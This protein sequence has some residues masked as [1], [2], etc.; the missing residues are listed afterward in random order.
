MPAV[1]QV[2]TAFAEFARWLADNRTLAVATIAI[3][4]N[5]FEGWLKFE[6]LMWLRE[7]QHLAIEGLTGDAGLEYK[8]SLDPASDDT[9]DVWKQCDLWVRATRGGFHYVELK[10]PFANKNSGKMLASAGYDFWY[11]S[12]LR[13]TEEEAASGSAIVVGVGF[14]DDRWEA[15]RARVRRAA[16][17]SSRVKPVRT[18]T[19]GDGI[20]FDVWTKTY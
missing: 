18:G 17:I 4:P 20:R 3:V 8:V 15:S 16:G 13:A 10:A 12:R 9:G 6:F 5:G 2:A 1:D 14:D 19:I 11:M 7:H